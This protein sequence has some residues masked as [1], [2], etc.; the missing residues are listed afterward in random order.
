MLPNG[1]TGVKYDLPWFWSL[2]C[3]KI[4]RKGGHQRTPWPTRLGTYYKTD[5]SACFSH[6]P[7]WLTFYFSRQIRIWA[8]T[9]SSWSHGQFSLQPSGGSLQPL[10]SL[11]EKHGWVNRTAGWNGCTGVVFFKQTNKQKM[12]SFR[13]AVCQ[14]RALPQRDEPV[15]SGGAAGAPVEAVQQ[16]GDPVLPEQSKPAR[17]LFFGSQTSIYSGCLIAKHVT[18]NGERL[19]VRLIHQRGNWENLFPFLLLLW[20]DRA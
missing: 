14:H 12:L 5:I 3:V 6:H 2:Y 15:Q 7:A 9:A 10:S 4:P 11:S 1:V 13:W 17:Q 20:S 16:R 19:K 8:Q 18:E